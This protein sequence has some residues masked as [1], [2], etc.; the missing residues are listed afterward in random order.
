MWVAGGAFIAGTVFVWPLVYEPAFNTFRPVDAETDAT[1]RSLAAEA[2]V[3]VGSVVVADASRRTSKRNAY[4]S[5]IGASR[6]VVLYDTLLQES[7]TSDV[8]LVVAHELAHV[9]HHDVRNGTLMGIGGFGIGIAALWALLRS[10]RVRAVAGAAHPSDPALIPFLA[11]F[12][13]AATLIALPANNAVSRSIE[14]RAD[15][16]A[17]ALTDDAPAAVR[18]EVNLARDNV[19]D[20]DPNAFIRW[21]LFT[22][23]STMERIEAAQ[24]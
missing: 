21:L 22:H 12:V 23:P 2:G 3:P 7:T 6:R 11:L 9:A 16:T 1:V 20:L 17:T 4:V 14:A 18:L 13:A 10:A 15:A 24:R 5:G 19:S 8:R